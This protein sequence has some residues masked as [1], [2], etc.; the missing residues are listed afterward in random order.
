MQTE[1]EV[2]AW[3]KEAREHMKEF[4]TFCDAI[5]YLA[6]LEIFFPKKAKDELSR[7]RKALNSLEKKL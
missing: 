1:V 4:D 6:K 2:A 5:E 3:V 7:M